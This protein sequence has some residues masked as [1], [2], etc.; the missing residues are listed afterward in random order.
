[1]RYGASAG[2]GWLDN[3]PAVIT[4]RV[5]RG[6]ITYIGA[7]FDSALMRGTAKA[8]VEEAG[9]QS[10][11]LPVPAGVEVCR[12]VGKSGEVFVVLNHGSAVVEFALPGK[13]ASVLDGGEVSGLKLPSHG[14]AVL[15]R[16]MESAK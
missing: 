9:V 5:G 7:L 8:L 16:N 15:T 11:T 4:R 12:R 13:M 1:M 3:Q 6:R 14:V 2:G 10:Q